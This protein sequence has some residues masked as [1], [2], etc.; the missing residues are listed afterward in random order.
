MF[1]PDRRSLRLRLLAALG[2]V[3]LL[4]VGS[5][6]VLHGALLERLARDFL[7]D[8]LQQ[9]A[10]LIER[11][12]HAEGTAPLS[13]P[14]GSPP[15]DTFH[16][17]YLLHVGERL[18]G[19]H[20]ALLTQPG[21]LLDGPPGASLMPWRE[22][23]VL[24]WRSRF[25]LDGEAATLVVGEDFA[26]IEQGLK[27]LHLWIGGISAALLGLLVVLN[28]V[29]VSRALRPF[30][31]LSRQLGEL[32]RGER[33]RIALETVSELRA[34]ID[35]LNTFLD[36]QERRQQRSRESLANLSHA[37]R[38]PLAAVMQALRARQ[39]PDERRRARMLE[40]LDDIDRKLGAELRRARIAG[41][42]T[43]QRHTGM[44]EVGS[45]LEMFRALYPDRRFDLAGDTR[46]WRLPLERQD[47]MEL[48]GIVLDNAGK[49]AHERVVLNLIAE[50]PG[51]AIADDGPGVPDEMLDRLGQRGWR[52]DAQRHGHGLGLS[53]LGQLVERYG[54]AVHYRRASEG[55]LCV[56]ISFLPR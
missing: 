26:T 42:A 2:V 16:H 23:R 22:R 52:L 7:A 46:E 28:L 3:A 54:G 8:R 49:W 35:Q 48:L 14:Y 36:E 30:A 19:T 27:R 24:V 55:G 20:Q 45:L 1:R 21:P 40:R 18:T 15:A 38:T 56:E 41:H 17:F 29:A 50:P 37:I 47:G 10:A 4:V 5:S 34:P 53:I 32:K 43:G 25:D 39:P 12:L 44:A 11:R 31:E 6:W 13:L 51:L 33:R 9:E